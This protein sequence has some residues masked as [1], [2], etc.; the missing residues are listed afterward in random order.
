MTYFNPISD[1]I[2][3]KFQCPDCEEEVVSH[4]M[5]VPT[6]DFTAENNS[7]SMVEDED[8]VVCGKCGRSFQ[9]TIYN[10]MYDGEVDVEDVDEVYVEEQY[11][12]EDEDYYDYQL[13]KATHS[14][15][16]D[17]LD[18]I[19]YLSSDVKSNLYR[20][21]YANIISKLEAFLCDTIV[22][23]VLSSDENKKKFLQTYEPLAEQKI[24][25]KAIYS[26][27]DALDNIIRTALKDIV[28]HNLK[29]VEKIYKNTLGIQI[30]K[31]DAIDDAIQIRHH[32]VHRNGKDKDGNL[33]EIS[34]EMVL[35]L[36]NTVS[37]F[38]YDIDN[39]LPN[40]AL[41]AIKDCLGDPFGA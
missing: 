26:K 33:V 13:Y 12:E 16:E 23:Q 40:P 24:P 7:D 5:N 9:V 36:A 1:S 31:V 34:K 39:Q 28:Y 37:T 2:I 29:L 14:E 18:A 3:I 10:S 41:N 21:L 38:I 6:P 11:A 19:E 32:I 8:E 4:S 30:P 20:L 15:T 25:M 17:T 22:K 27:Y 35:E